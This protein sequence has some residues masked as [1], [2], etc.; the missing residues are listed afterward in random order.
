MKVIARYA[1][2]F[3]TLLTLA[4]CAPP[5]AATSGTPEDEAAIRA[6]G[7]KVADVW[8]KGD[9]VGMSAMLTDD[10]QTI[11][12]DG[13]EIKGKA[14]A[15]ASN[16]KD[17]EQRAGLGLKLSIDTKYVRWVSA[18]AAQ[19]GGTWSLAGV[20]A[21]M[22]SDKGAWMMLDV[23]GADGQWR[24]AN[25]LVASYQP[26]PAPPAATPMPPAKGKIK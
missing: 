21:G 3:A 2:L 14:A 1:F 18:T 26:P 11:A 15:E 10:Y 6:M 9:A 24:M 12:P 17:A 23:K 13:T 5:S 7:A 19:V 25:G 8:T 4:A 16:K 20:P 22:G